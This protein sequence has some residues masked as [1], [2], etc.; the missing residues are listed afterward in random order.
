MKIYF[1]FLDTFT[2]ALEIF[3]VTSSSDSA[4]FSLALIVGENHFLP[5]KKMWEAF[6]A[7]ASTPLINSW[8]PWLQQT[9]HRQFYYFSSFPSGA[10]PGCSA[11]CLE[12]IFSQRDEILSVSDLDRRHSECKMCLMQGFFNFIIGSRILQIFL[13][14]VFIVSCQ[15]CVWPPSSRPILQN[16]I[17][18]W[19]QP[20]WHCSSTVES[21]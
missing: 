17:S 2:R 9:P 13:F 10:D 8:D 14:M 21:R 18:Q 20:H 12:W 3:K 4:S 5:R 16:D 6:P 7:S 11:A 19:Y 15:N 1:I